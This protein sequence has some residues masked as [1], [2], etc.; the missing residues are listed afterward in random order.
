MTSPRLALLAEAV[1]LVM[2]KLR[3]VPIAQRPAAHQDNNFLSPLSLSY[4]GCA[5]ALVLSWPLGVW[6]VEGQAKSV[7]R[8]FLNAEFK[9]L[10]FLIE[11]V[12]VRVMTR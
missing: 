10:P 1:P 8:A 5:V 3:P 2:V 9:F 4:G 11:S 12:Q 7:R 6:D